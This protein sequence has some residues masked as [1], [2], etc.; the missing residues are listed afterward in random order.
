M[1]IVY[2]LYYCLFVFIRDLAYAA[3]IHPYSLKNTV[4]IDTQRLRKIRRYHA[5]VRDDTNIRRGIS[6]Q[7][8]PEGVVYPLP[9]F[10]DAFPSRDPG[11]RRGFKPG[12]V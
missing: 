4:E 12:S 9:K 8:R 1:S 7:Y 5:P 2:A 3:I 11:F 10:R 6:S